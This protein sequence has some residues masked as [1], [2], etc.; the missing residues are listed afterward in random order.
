MTMRAAAA[1][2]QKAKKVQ[3]KLNKQEQQLCATRAN[4]TR[5]E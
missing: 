3:R 2:E 5:T 4:E 1:A